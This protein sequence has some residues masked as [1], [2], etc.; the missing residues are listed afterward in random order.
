MRCGHGLETISYYNRHIINPH[1]C[2]AESASILRW[3]SRASASSMAI[4]RFIVGERLTSSEG[5]EPERN[6][7]F[8]FS[9]S[10]LTERGDEDKTRSG[11]DM[12]VVQSDIHRM[13]FVHYQS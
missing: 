11:D 2:M 12:V 10:I 3:R 9:V 5:V 8:A 6:C 7:Q 4:V 13:Q 1:S